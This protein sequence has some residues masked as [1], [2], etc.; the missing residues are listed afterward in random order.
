[1]HVPG[2]GQSARG[3]AKIKSTTAFAKHYLL[4]RKARQ[5]HR[6][7]AS[8]TQEFVQRRAATHGFA[9][10]AGPRRIGTQQ[11]RNEATPYQGNSNLKA[12]H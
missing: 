9:I 4:G 10:E 12:Q 11:G 3:I 8:T 5:D 7:F 1:M 6:R 2:S